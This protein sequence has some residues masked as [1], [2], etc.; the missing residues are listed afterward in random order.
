MMLREELESLLA[1]RPA[2][3]TSFLKAA[4]DETQHGAVYT[5][6]I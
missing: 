2:T 4:K 3:R 1:L 5:C 6:W